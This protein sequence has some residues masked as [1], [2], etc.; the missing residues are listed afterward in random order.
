MKDVDKEPEERKIT[1]QDL[2]FFVEKFEGHDTGVRHSIN[3]RKKQE[4]KAWTNQK[5]QQTPQDE[6]YDNGIA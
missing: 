5:E 3:S 4:N 1:L 6:I 2:L